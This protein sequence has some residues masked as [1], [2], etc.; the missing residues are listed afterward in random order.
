MMRKQASPF[1]LFLCLFSCTPL[2]IARE[3]TWIE[4]KSPGFTIISNASPKQ[5]RRTARSFEQFGLLLKTVLPQFKADPGSPLTVFAARDGKTFE[6]LLPRRYEKGAS[7]VFGMFMSSPERNF[8]ALRLDVP[9]EKAY[10][11]I[12]H[13]Y[14]HMIM[15][16]NF[17]QMPLWLSEGLAE[18]FAYS[19]VSDGESTVG[20]H[21]PETILALKK[22]SMMPLPALMAVTWDSPYYTETDKAAIF[23]AQSWALT[24][25]LMLGDK[26][27]HAKQLDDFLKLLQSSVPEQEA[28]ARALGDINSLQQNLRAYVNAGDFYHYSVPAR[29]SVKEEEYEV[30]DLSRAE[31]L[32]LR[33]QF[34]VGSDRRQEARAMFEEALRLDS[35]NTQA[36]EGM[37]LLFLKLGDQEQ[38]GKYF[39]AA[40]QLNSQS[41]LAQYYAA[42]SEYQRGDDYGAAESYLRKALDIN[43][44]FV[45]A[46][47]ML[48]HIL[49]FD[50]KRLPEA[51]ELALKAASLEPAELRHSLNA[52]EILIAMD[53][54]DEASLV[55]ER[56]L[57]LAV[58]DADQNLA[59]SMILRIKDHRDR[60][61][62]A[63]R[64]RE[65]PTKKAQPAR[66][67]EEYRQERNGAGEKSQPPSL[68]SAKKGPARSM[69]GVVTSVQCGYPATMDIVLESNGRQSKF[70][71]ENYYK[72]QYEAIGSSGGSDFEPCEELQG[73]T[74]QI[75]YTVV[76][77]REFSGFLRKIGI[78]K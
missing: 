17:P 19:R 70:H 72:L 22:Y 9:E 33:G 24:H 57:A 30:R 1:Y 47:S 48:S 53:R 23:Y 32:A 65:L 49:S 28:V 58:K 11:I 6:A 52:G 45:P 15:R 27:A 64:P 16:L 43:P 3:E 62:E 38:A 42:Q 21:S 63:T 10:H 39:A 60:V 4:V 54:F 7:Q 31:S 8:V 34:L 5:A 69:I 51:L 73:Q 36:N 44:K 78:V 66:K 26:A 55:A 67:I 18:L 71:A 77:G 76:S 59:E 37:G 46:C 68:P 74:V 29:L 20:Y 75:E 12:Y 50:E 25:Y 41:F 35:R 61:L 40:A 14:V 56:V 13:E 2:C